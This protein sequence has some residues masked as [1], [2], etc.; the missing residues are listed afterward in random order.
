MNTLFIPKGLGLTVVIDKTTPEVISIAQPEELLKQ[1][2]PSDMECHYFY[3]DDNDN[4]KSTEIVNF[5]DTSSKQLILF[6]TT[7]INASW[8][9]N[10]MYTLLSKMTEQHFVVMVQILSQRLWDGTGLDVLTSFHIT[11]SFTNDSLVVD[12]D[13]VDENTNGLKIPVV[14][15]TDDEMVDTLNNSFVD[16]SHWIN[17]TILQLKT[18]PIVPKEKRCFT[19]K[20]RMSRFYAMASPTAQKMAGLITSIPLTTDN[21]IWLWKQF[22]PNSSYIPLLEIFYGGLLKRN[23]NPLSQVDFLFQDAELH[24]L[25]SDMILAVEMMEVL[26]SFAKSEF[27]SKYRE[28]LDMMFN[29]QTPELNG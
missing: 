27:G 2:I 21:M 14:S 13:D 24:Y 16:C 17:G 9:N 3:H 19:A 22:F 15:I 4:A 26:I 20:E 25:L 7:C 10:Q 12:I 8:D 28:M 29:G 1:I 6:V 23:K 11:E 5:L 18:T